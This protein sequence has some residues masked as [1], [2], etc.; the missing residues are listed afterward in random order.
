MQSSLFNIIKLFFN[1]KEKVVGDFIICINRDDS[2]DKN[3]NNL[4][5]K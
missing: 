1:E 4:C 2:N 5:S 3:F